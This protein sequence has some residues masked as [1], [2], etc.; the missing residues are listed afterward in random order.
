[1]SEFHV[2]VVRIGPIEKHPNA[3]TLGITHVH[4]GYPVIVKLGDFKEGDLAVYVPVDAIVDGNR[5]EFSFLGERREH[6]IKAKKLRGVFSMGLL[7]QAS[8]IDLRVPGEDMQAYLGI[9][10]YVP[11]SEREQA[12][13]H[14]T[15]RNAK[16]SEL[17][18]FEDAAAMTSI[19]FTLCYALMGILF[20]SPG[21]AVTFITIWTMIIYV[22]ILGNRVVHKKPNVPVYDIEGFRKYKNVFE[23]G[24]PVV[25]TEKIHGCNARYVHTGL[26]F[27]VG[28]RTMFRSDKTNHWRTAANRCDLERKL[29][30]Y[31]NIVLFGE[32][33]G[34]ECQDLHY[35][36]SPGSVRFAAFDAMDLKTRRYLDTDEFGRVMRELDIPTVPILYR[37][38][39]SPE[40]VSLA[41]GKATWGG[42][43]VR[44]GIV[45]KPAR[46][47]T[48]PGLGRT[49]LKL[50]GEG[51]LL[52]KEAR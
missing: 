25:I 5:P 21:P 23:P 48:T 26:K 9:E 10:K 18:N 30:S 1:M 3:D 40:L 8:G 46:E 37:G 32:I 49:F 14:K 7:V 24:E 35:G 47:R 39:W 36:V 38:P 11:A 2:T 4:G 22:M 29:K 50:V 6:R 44:E 19:T 52:R 43:H 41:E 34:P 28:S 42:H 16:P 31:P 27:H 45:I 12:P 51:Y 20:N 13:S 17:K 15:E 33:Y